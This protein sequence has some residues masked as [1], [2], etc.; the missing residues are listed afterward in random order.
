MAIKR[1]FGDH[2]YGVPISSTKSVTGH[3]LGAAGGVE[4]IFCVKAITD[5]MLPPTI[6]Q[7]V[8]DPDCDLDY[9]PNE[10]RPARINH[11]MCNSMGFG[12]HN[13]VVIFSRYEG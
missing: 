7:E 1:A 11:A 8:P 13:G 9:I 4:A 3:L 5:G 12:G 10:A 6:N 2:A